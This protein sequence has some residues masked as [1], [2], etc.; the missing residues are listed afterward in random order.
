M[1]AAIL[2]LSTFTYLTSGLDLG[3]AGVFDS[4]LATDEYVKQFGFLFGGGRSGVEGL[5]ALQER[6]SIHPSPLPK[7]TKVAMDKSDDSQ[8]KHMVELS[9]FTPNTGRGGSSRQFSRFLAV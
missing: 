3:S 9:P 5:Q 6:S 7:Q 4:P 2:F 1:K 8:E